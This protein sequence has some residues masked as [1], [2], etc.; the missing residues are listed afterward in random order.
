MKL[1]QVRVAGAS[2]A[3]NEITGELRRLRG[4]DGNDTVLIPPSPSD[5]AE[6]CSLLF[7]S[8]AIAENWSPI[9]RGEAYRRTMRAFHPDTRVFAH[10]NR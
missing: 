7:D 2:C 9:S 1:Q 10:P 4:S 3:L 8:E 6:A 5:P